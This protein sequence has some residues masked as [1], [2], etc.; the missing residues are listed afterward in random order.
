MTESRD[1]FMI[2]SGDSLMNEKKYTVGQVAGALGLR[3][4][5]FRTWA[6]R[7]YFGLS[8]TEAG[9]WRKFSA[10]D[11]ARLAAIAS[12]TAQGLS[13]SD[14]AHVIDCPITGPNYW[15]A[16][17][18]RREKHIF[19]CVARVPGDPIDPIISEVYAC[20]DQVQTFLTEPTEGCQGAG[21]ID[22]Q[23][24]ARS[25]FDVGPAVSAAVQALPK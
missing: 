8:E 24:V 13:V 7:H 19:V 10:Q 11:V 2:E 6:R 4:A 22:L 9:Q 18:E 1:S 14:A 12:L 25:V 5:A 3:L 17:V 23:P 20:A 16:L 15:H 21:G